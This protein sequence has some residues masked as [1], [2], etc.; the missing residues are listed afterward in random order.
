MNC[1]IITEN[2]PTL[3][4]IGCDFKNRFFY[5]QDAIEAVQ[6]QQYIKNL[7]DNG[8]ITSYKEQ[9]YKSKIKKANIMI[10]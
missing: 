10:N 7:F 3:T 2:F 8:K 1:S 6:Q 9:S 4:V 5:Y